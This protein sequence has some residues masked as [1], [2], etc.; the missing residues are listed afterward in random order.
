[1]IPPVCLYIAD[2]KEVKGYKDVLLWGCDAQKAEKIEN[3][4]SNDFDVYISNVLALS[5]GYRKKA[6]YDL[7]N[8][9]TEVHERFHNFLEEK[10]G[11]LRMSP[12]AYVFNENFACAVEDYW[13]K[14]CVRSFENEEG[15]AF[16]DHIQRRKYRSNRF[17]TDRYENGERVNNARKVFDGLF[18]SLYPEASSVLEEH[19]IE[20]SIE[21][22]AD[23]V[24][25]ACD[26]GF[27]KGLEYFLSYLP[28]S[29]R[30]LVDVKNM[31]SNK[32]KVESYH[33]ET[34][35]PEDLAAKISYGIGQKNVQ[36]IQTV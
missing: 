30:E 33:C 17:R 26:V 34:C 21:I 4:L 23:T 3:L 2:K 31:L 18:Y 16:L 5:T 15:M 11:S 29:K 19:D 13:V 32:F 7:Q 25:K 36:G 20:K 9:A 8:I 24:K 14:M 35:T 28:E 22:F 12:Q 10:V 6:S 27:D 1:M